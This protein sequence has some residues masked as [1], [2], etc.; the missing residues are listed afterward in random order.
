MCMVSRRARGPNSAPGPELDATGGS[1]QGRWCERRRVGPAREA[2]PAISQSPALL[3]PTPPLGPGALHLPPA[4]QVWA[5][6]GPDGAIGSRPP[7]LLAVGGVWGSSRAGGRR[8]ALS[9]GRLHLGDSP[10]RGFPRA[11]WCV[12]RGAVGGLALKQDPFPGRSSL[13][14]CLPTQDRATLGSTPPRE[15]GGHCSTGL[16]GGGK[17]GGG[18]RVLGPGAFQSWQGR[19][20]AGWV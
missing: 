18:S 20:A 8:S 1:G 13:Q 16:L 6:G 9:A 15:L 12:G 3:P 2:R 10:G 5:R 7:S 4:P 17:V 14:V 11:T 19:P